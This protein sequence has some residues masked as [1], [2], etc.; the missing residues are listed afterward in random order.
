MEKNER[1][2]LETRRLPNDEQNFLV[3]IQREY[4]LPFTV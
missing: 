2:E 3:I 1:K 4:R